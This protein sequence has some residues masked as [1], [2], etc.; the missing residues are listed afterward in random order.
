[1]K[2]KA[3]HHNAS[4]NWEHLSLVV[5]YFENS[6]PVEK[7]VGIFTTHCYQSIMDDAGLDILYILFFLR[8]NG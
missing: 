7:A 1:M 3:R 8:D 6:T 5:R 2:L 4:N